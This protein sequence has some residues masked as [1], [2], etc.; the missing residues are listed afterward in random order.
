MVLGDVKSQTGTD[1]LL[2]WSILSLDSVERPRSS[3]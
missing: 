3:L 1:S 2:T